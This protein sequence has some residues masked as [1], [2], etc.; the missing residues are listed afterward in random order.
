MVTSGYPPAQTAGLER[1]CQ[2]LAE[3]VARRGV[4]VTV[5]T[6]AVPQCDADVE[7]NGV[8]VLRVL[9][10]WGFGPAWG[11][12]YRSQVRRWLMRLLPQWDVV[13][14]HQLYLHSIEANRVAHAQGRRACHLLVAA[15][16]YSDVLRLARLR[17]GKRLLR[18][19]VD[20]AQALFVLSEVS[21]SEL[22]AVG[23][24]PSRVHDYRYFVDT[25]RFSPS[26][27][28]PERE[29]LCLGRWHPQK[30][31]PL[32]VDAFDIV[33]A[34]HPGVRLRIVGAGPEEGTVRA[35]VASSPARARIRVEGWAS[36]P[37]DAYRAAWALVMSSDAEGLSNVL[38]ESMSTG[39]PVV[40]TDVSGAREVLDLGPASNPL[41]AGTVLRGAGGFMVPRGDTQAPA[42]AMRRLLASPDERAEAAAAA[43]LRI[44]D[45][46]TEG[47]SVALIEGGL[48]T[49][50][51]SR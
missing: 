23:A 43:R 24:Q 32:L 47:S 51:G 4:R 10:P 36:D 34:Q 20:G 41:V 31:I 33:A 49:G 35:R 15:Q 19:A 28:I 2:R 48:A 1:G 11:W 17:H 45:A 16:D 50:Q 13:M 18:E 9:R 38:I 26:P 14:C 6:S 30:N 8:R 25:E 7:E 12:T 5:L 3:A 37:L 40:T 27:A 22:L 42:E 46:F 29:F 21:R 39:V 44:L